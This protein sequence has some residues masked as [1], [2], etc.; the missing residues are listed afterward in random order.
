LA[1]RRDRYLEAG[2]FDETLRNDF[3]DVDFCLK[4]GECG[5]RNLYTPHVRVMHHESLTRSYRVADEEERER[6]YERWGH[7][8]A[9][10]PHISP[11]FDRTT[12]Q[13]ALALR[14][15]PGEA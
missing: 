12:L 7:K 9:R 15:V 10:D 13:P 8:L 14:P 4:L 2:G 3:N 6:M 5:L 1:V 11:H